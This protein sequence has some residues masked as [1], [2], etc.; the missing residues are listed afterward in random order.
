MV[1]SSQKSFFD[2]FGTQWKAP[3]GQPWPQQGP[4]WPAKLPFWPI[5]ANLEG[6]GAKKMIFELFWGLKNHSLR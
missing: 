1:S 2:Y 6:F 3:W 4:K 5:L